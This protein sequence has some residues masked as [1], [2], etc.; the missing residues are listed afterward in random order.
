MG[1]VTH[2]TDRFYNLDVFCIFGSFLYFGSIKQK[3]GENYE[4]IFRKE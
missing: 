2:I 1:N 3:E 4:V